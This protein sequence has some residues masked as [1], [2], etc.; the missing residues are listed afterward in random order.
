MPYN[1]DSSLHSTMRDFHAICV[2]FTHA[3]WSKQMMSVKPPDG[4]ERL[5]AHRE[6][7]SRC[8]PAN[9]SK[10]WE[11]AHLRAGRNLTEPRP[12]MLRCRDQEQA[13]NR[14]SRVGGIGPPFTA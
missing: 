8:A 5:D 4:N 1:P 9:S 3:Q 11:E 7:G 2:K 14:R 12:T 10:L 6:L 13:M